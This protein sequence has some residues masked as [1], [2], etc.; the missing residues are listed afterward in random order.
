MASVAKREG[1]AEP[2]QVR[3]RDPEGR[4]RARQFRRKVDA[5]RFLV[6]Q[7]HLKHT[8]G[9][10]DAS[11]GKTTFKTYAEAWRASQP[12][13]RPQTASLYER[14]LRLHAYPT[15]GDR[16]MAGVR[17]SEVQG[18]V[19]GL[20]LAPAT[21]RQV[22]A[23]TRTIFRAAVEDKM[24]AESPCRK[25]GLPELPD[26][27]LVPLT[28]QQV[29]AVADAAPADL[30]AL[31]ILAAATGLRSG[32]LLG[33]TVD[34]VD[35]LRRTVAVDQQ[36]VYVSGRPPFLGPPKTRASR[37]TVPAPS[38]ALDELAAHLARSPS[39]GLVFRSPGGKPTLRTTLN[40][41]W[42]RAVRDAGLADT[43]KLHHLRHH[44]ASVL[45]A[46]GESVKVVQ[47]RLGHASAVET[48]RTYAHLWPDDDERTRSVVESA[49]AAE[50]APGVHQDETTSG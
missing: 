31:V 19:A 24:I 38:F 44:F 34:K 16:P 2:Y 41:R 4:Q 30:R 9:Y 42:R 50:C 20:G 22:Y 32:E 6:E 7:E 12:H 37:R 33:L 26:S 5:E 1:R 18:W 45:I 36:L 47:E 25:I 48:L 14:L 23:V 11:A 39:A 40:G 27:T 46:G 29:R 3:W 35:F 13:H 15:L 49:W 43:V 21:V 10:I 17:R 8:G 28:V